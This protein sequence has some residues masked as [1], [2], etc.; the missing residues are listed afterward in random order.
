MLK[1][2]KIKLT[3]TKVKST[4]CL[5]PKSRK[6]Y[7]KTKAV[8]IEEDDDEYDANNDSEYDERTETKITKNQYKKKDSLIKCLDTFAAKTVPDDLI[9]KESDEK[10]YGIFT[11][12]QILKDKLFGPFIGVRFEHF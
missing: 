6:K 5:R 10:E 11:M 4:S 8:N 1:S 2:Q 7:Y 3:Y 12:K 9:L